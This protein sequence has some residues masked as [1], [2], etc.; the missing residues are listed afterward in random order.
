MPHPGGP[1][2]PLLALL[3]LALAL[4]AHYLFWGW[5]YR[6]RADS[7]AVLTAT[8]SDGWQLAVAWFKPARPNGGSPV[9]LC[10]GL[11][12]NRFNM[13]LPGTH[14]LAAFLRD[15]GHEVF[16]VD[17]RGCGD[18]GRPPKG[19]RGS[20]TF[21]DHVLRD[22]PAVLELVKARS[23]KPSALWVGHSMGG[24][25]GLAVAQLEAG[26]SLAG[27][28]ALGSP[29]RWEFHRP[30]LGHVLRLSVKLAFL[31][32]IHNKWLARIFAPWL[33]FVPLPMNDVALNPQN[34]DLR[35]YR[36]VAY[37]VL[38]DSSRAMLR[39][40]ASWFV[41]NAWDLAETGTDLRAGL[42]RIRCPVLLMGG[43]MDVLAPPQAVERA[44]ADVGSA[45]KML[46]L[47]GQSRGDKQDYGHGDLIFGRHAPEEVFPELERW[48]S[49]HGPRAAA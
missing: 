38:A 47:F 7:D 12:A 41:R 18:S 1:L 46:V 6:L 34:M 40:F 28:A 25:I 33:G 19:K 2:L 20:W 24:L 43:A 45:D 30:L 14:S 4:A 35:L 15:H 10:H 21:D 32:R 36:R 16:A 22:A 29:T 11:A 27:V 13:C 48:L 5:F 42:A 23:G 44:L 39:Q 9:I 17:L 3:A 49:A 8:C 37:T 31:G 26:A